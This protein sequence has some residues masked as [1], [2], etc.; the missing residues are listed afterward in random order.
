M[1]ASLPYE[2]MEAGM[3]G[4]HSRSQKGRSSWENFNPARSDALPILRNQSEKA[5]VFLRRVSPSAG[6][7][8]Q[9]C[10]GGINLVA[11]TGRARGIGSV[12][13][14]EES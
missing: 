1:F 6:W 3:K 5:K 4:R 13:V 14:G 10:Q 11:R 7:R 8:I 9:S 2:T 12:L